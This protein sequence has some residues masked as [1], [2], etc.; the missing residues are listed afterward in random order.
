MWKAT[1]TAEITFTLFHALVRLV[2]TSVGDF[3]RILRCLPN[4]S[5]N[6]IIWQTFIACSANSVEGTGCTGSR[7][8][9]KVRS[10]MKEKTQKATANRK[11]VLAFQN[12][13][14]R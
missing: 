10:L 11:K 6:D 14:L 8:E 7:P 4:T 12:R 1:L 2:D 5:G 9:I 13:Q 3:E